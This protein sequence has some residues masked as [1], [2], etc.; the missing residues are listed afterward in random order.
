MRDREIALALGALL[1]ILSTLISAWLWRR[2][3]YIR[4][5]VGPGPLK[6]K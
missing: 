4:I 5:S 2:N 3:G 6:K 1:G